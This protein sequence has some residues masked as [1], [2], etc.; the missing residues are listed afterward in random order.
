MEASGVVPFVLYVQR[1]TCIT[2]WA[3][4]MDPVTPRVLAGHTNMNTTKRYVHPNE[5]DIL[6]A[7]GKVQGVH[8]S[9]H[10]A[11]TGNTEHVNPRP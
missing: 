1:Q 5:A 3:K 9:R 2:G 7:T 11:E 4:H 10:S 8:N 6:E